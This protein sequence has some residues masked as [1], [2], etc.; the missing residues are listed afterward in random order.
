MKVAFATTFDGRDV[1][2]WS[3]TPYYMSKG[4]ADGGLQVEYIGSLSRKVAPFFKIKQA[5]KK[6]AAGQRE[7]PRHNVIAAQ[8]YSRQVAEKLKS[9]HADVIISPQINP[10]AYLDVKQPL[11]LWTDAL[12]ASLI[13]FN[14][15][16]ANHSASSI[17]QGNIITA[18][19]LSRCALAVFS[20][21]WAARTALEIY[22]VDK[23]KVKVVPFG[24]NLHCTHKLSDIKHMLTLRS[25]KTVKLLFLSKRW[26]MKDG[27]KVLA[28]AKA[29]HA[30]GQA[31][32]L[33]IVGCHPPKNEVLPSYVK[34][35]GFISKR[36]PEGVVQ[37]TKLL[38][39]SH[40][41]FVPSRS[42][43]FGIVFCEANAFGLPCLTTYIGGISSVVKDNVNGMTFS[44]NASPTEYCDYIMRLMATYAD[45][46]ALALSAF[47]EYETR[48]NW[49]SATVSLRKLINEII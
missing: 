12:Y 3:G 36:T 17:A 44:L 33:H 19:C 28:V 13:G 7:S 48:L 15:A 22:G 1:S 45:Y 46:E 21:D 2:N 39:E 9:I 27:K 4:L 41:L 11:V 23:N 24:A 25:R 30:C 42:E 37:I 20:S 40:F 38:E 29:L 31:V 26:E 14:P 10:I 34:C 8:H 16:F 49:Q 6:F 5:W 32:E 47:N 35:H 43:A 18:E